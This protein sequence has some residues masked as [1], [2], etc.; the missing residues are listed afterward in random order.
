MHGYSKLRAF[1]PKGI[2][3]IRITS[4][5]QEDIKWYR[6]KGLGVLFFS[7]NTKPQVARLGLR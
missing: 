7:W 3:L 4:G 2:I 6:I 5:K 1:R